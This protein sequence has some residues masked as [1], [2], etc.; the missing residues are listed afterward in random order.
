MKNVLKSLCVAFVFAGAI[1]CNDA[2]K[3]VSSAADD[4]KSAASNADGNADVPVIDFYPE[5]GNIIPGA[6]SRIAGG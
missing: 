1:S 2:P 3:S 5:G 6:A 4:A